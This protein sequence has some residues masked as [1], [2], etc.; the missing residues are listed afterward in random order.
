MPMKIASGPE[1]TNAIKGDLLLVASCGV[2]QRVALLAVAEAERMAQL[3]RQRLVE[4]AQA[5]GRLR[6]CAST[7]REVHSVEQISLPRRW[8]PRVTDA[9]ECGNALAIGQALRSMP[10]TESPSAPSSATFGATAVLPSSRKRGTAQCVW[11]Q[12]A[13]A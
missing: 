12:S 2:H 9:R 11:L 13:S 1:I 8:H 5:R 10:P 7:P 4:H 6:R 3:V